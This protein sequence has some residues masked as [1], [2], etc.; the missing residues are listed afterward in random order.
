MIIRHLN[1]GVTEPRGGRLMGGSGHPLRTVHGVSHC[2]L[3]ETE[4]GLVLIDS[5]FG[6][7]DIAH[8]TERLGKRFLRLARP[9][10][11]PQHTAVRQLSALGYDPRDVRH[12][13][14]THLDP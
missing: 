13:V 11:D 5:G 2:L 7:D 10:L 12:L 6:L 8:P 9:V 4:N 3:V 14:L 1:C